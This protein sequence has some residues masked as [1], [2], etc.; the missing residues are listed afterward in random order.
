[1]AAYSLGNTL[2]LALGRAA[3]G[4][5]MELAPEFDQ[6]AMEQPQNVLNLFLYESTLIPCCG[7]ILVVVFAVI[8]MKFEKQ[9]PKWQEELEQRKAAVE[10]E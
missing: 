7:F 10:Q 3:A 8:L 2:G 9:L 6:N 1:M 5:L 4:Y